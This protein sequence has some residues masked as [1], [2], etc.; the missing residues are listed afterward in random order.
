MSF[1]RTYSIRPAVPQ[2]PS[3]VPQSSRTSSSRPG[4]GRPSS[5]RPSAARRSLSPK[6]HAH[7]LSYFWVL[8][9]AGIAFV[10]SFITQTLAMRLMQSSATLGVMLLVGGCSAAYFASGY[11]TLLSAP[12][13][14]LREPALAAMLA[15]LATQVLEG[16]LHGTETFVATLFVA[17]IAYGAAIIGAHVARNL[18]DRR[19]DEA[20]A[21]RSRRP[22]HAIYAG[23]SSL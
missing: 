2:T 18:L 8:A 5:V 12:S 14:S 4:S 23:T 17:V 10:P 19:T 13:K 1:G 16:A 22:A 3:L 20:V 6:A 9:G 15:A 11:T 7:E 21:R